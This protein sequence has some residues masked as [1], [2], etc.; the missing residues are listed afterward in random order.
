MLRWEE[1]N[2][3]RPAIYC[4]DLVGEVWSPTLGKL[5]PGF[6]WGWVIKGKRS[7]RFLAW[8]AVQQEEV[9]HFYHK[10]RAKK[11]LVASVVEQVLMR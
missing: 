9:G 6:V 1:R 7:E 4:A 10:S 5:V 8:N 11:A 3:P 2:D